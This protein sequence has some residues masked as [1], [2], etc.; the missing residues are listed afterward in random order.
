GRHVEGLVV[1][2]SGPGEGVTEKE[3]PLFGTP[4][5]LASR[6]VDGV[7]ADAVIVDDVGGAF[8]GTSSLLA[9]G[10]R[11]IGYLGNSRSAFTDIRRYEGYTSAL[12]AA[13]AAV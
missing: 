10:H 2:P 9:A 4:M 3:K 13:G 8:D 6:L 7:E 12:A 11:R 5:V 1:V